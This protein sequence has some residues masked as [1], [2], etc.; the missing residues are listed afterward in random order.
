MRSPA[1]T[2]SNPL[3]RAI[4][5]RDQDPS[6]FRQTV[7][8]AGLSAD[9]VIELRGSLR[10]SKS[11]RL[12]CVA[13]A[14]RGREFW[15]GRTPLIIGRAPECTAS[16]AS[17]DVSRR[18]AAVLL[19]GDQYVIEDVGSANGTFVNQVPV[20][21]RTTLSVGDR[22]QIGPTTVLVFTVHDELEARMRQLDRV[23]A[24]AGMIAGLAHDFRNALQVI[25]CSLD[26]I[27]QGPALGE[28]QRR[29]TE[30]ARHAAGSAIALAKNLIN[31]GRREEPEH[32]PIPVAA[33]V[34]EVVNGARRV[35]PSN[36]DIHVAIASSFV[37]KG[38]REDCKR[39]FHN[40]LLNAR[41]AMPSGGRISI[42]AEAVQLSRAAAAAK[43]L[44]RG[45]SYIVISVTDTG[46]GM[47][48]DTVARIF[49]PYFTTK[50]PGQGSGLGL[51]MVHAIV[52]RHSGTI[53]VET[54]EGRG[55]SFR[56]WLPN[57][58]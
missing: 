22:I 13:G 20:I 31:V 54:E 3:S 7:T 42:T 37:G 52:R 17:A 23:E 44:T 55:S 5:K 9:E 53:E 34:E 19:D 32:Q 40:L 28:E 39:V 57:A 25:E 35:I 38:S 33:L 47:D 50:L 56:V 27:E 43:D 29:A 30:D 21:E 18:H 41:D 48:A 46:V 58:V 11:N 16:L 49:E 15:L 51:A 2:K 14:D 8:T 6:D 10:A 45:G 4:T 36:V 26:A 24:M 12:V 1:D